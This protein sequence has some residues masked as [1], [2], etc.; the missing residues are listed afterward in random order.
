MSTTA[1]P[2]CYRRSGRFSSGI[3][4]FISVARARDHSRLLS[5]PG[6]RGP[7]LSPPRRRGPTGRVA[8]SRQPDWIPACAGMTA[9]LPIIRPAAHTITQHGCG[10][11]FQSGCTQRFSAP[12]CSACVCLLF[13][14]PRVLWQRWVSTDSTD[15]RTCVCRGDDSAT[16]MDV[17][18]G[19]LA[20]LVLFLSSPSE[21]MGTWRMSNVWVM[22]CAVPATTCAANAA[23]LRRSPMHTA[24]PHQLQ[25][26]RC[27]LQRYR[28]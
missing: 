22:T 23:T 19:R 8:E 20:P 21:E 10:C 25:H 27:C 11:S 26:T 18:P 24:F 28:G 17:R 13:D 5:S 15:Q 2:A 4:G 12:C 9:I 1:A 7:N 3:G 6:S 14:S 16:G